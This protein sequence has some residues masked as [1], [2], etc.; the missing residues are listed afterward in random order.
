MDPTTLDEI[1]WMYVAA[2]SLLVAA[3]VL[4]VK[5][6]APQLSKLGAGIS[7]LRTQDADA[8]GATAPGLA[9][10]LSAAGTY[11]AAAAIG[12]ATAISLGGAGAIAW[13]WLFGL[14]LAPLRFAETL[15]A[16]TDAPGK[17]QAPGSLAGRLMRDDVAGV[18]FLGFAFLATLLAAGFLY[19]GGVQGGAVLDA[20]NQLSPESAPLIVLGV[21]AVGAALALAGEKRGAA[22]AGWLGV[23]GLLVVFAV[24]A[25]SALSEPGRAIGIFGRAIRDATSGAPTAGAFSGA[26]A[27]EVAFA[28]IL[29]LLPP[30]AATTGS[31]GVAHHLGSAATTRG[32]A[33]ASVLGPFLYA[34][35]TTAVGAALIASGALYERV[36]DERPLSELKVFEVAFESA[37]QR[38]E[39]DRLFTGAMR[40]RDGT[41]LDTRPKPATHRGMVHDAVY[42][43]D[44]E[45]AD[46]AMQL[47]DGSLLRLM[48]PTDTG[49]LSDADPLREKEIT[50]TGR[51]LPEDGQLF[52]VGLDD[53][54]GGGL[55]SQA[56]IAGLLSLTAVAVALWGFALRRSL[57]IGSPAALGAAVAVLPA[58]GVVVAAFSVLPWLGVAGSVAAALVATVGALALLARS[59]QAA[60]LSR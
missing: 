21:A 55:S 27:G 9:L 39:E 53:G 33:A 29:Y 58:L 37:S 42:R 36:D 17:S 25:I 31:A 28:A 43:F 2:P 23:V 38:V 19:V 35:L 49:A 5:L 41:T 59:G 14:L 12:A 45:L 22:L 46:I 57:P 44:G 56:A 18:R 4:T 51:M 6:R 13:V 30:I 11:G 60:K 50:V 54:P 48:L 34:I 47:E 32:Q 16:R 40:L 7:A 3:L 15:L 8:P 1:L 52:A 10:A 26:F 24:A 20:A